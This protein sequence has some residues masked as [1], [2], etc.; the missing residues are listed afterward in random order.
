MPAG[1][2]LALSATCLQ[3]FYSPY[4]TVF[5]IIAFT[6]PWYI[7]SPFVCSPQPV[8]SKR[9]GTL[10][11]VRLSTQFL[12]KCQK[13]RRNLINI[14]WMS[15]WINS[16]GEK[17][18]KISLNIKIQSG[19]RWSFVSSWLVRSECLS[20]GKTDP[21]LELLILKSLPFLNRWLKSHCTKHNPYNHRW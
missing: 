11:F 18:K 17:S 13:H 7:F 20:S 16:R 21:R 10:S 8:S 4:P 6:N 1:K 5:F 14:G 19:Q 9:S 15:E 12:E 2:Q 3:H